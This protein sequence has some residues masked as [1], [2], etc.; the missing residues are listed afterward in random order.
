MSRRLLRFLYPLLI[1]VGLVVFASPAHAATGDC[2]KA[3]VAES[4]GSGLSGFFS[5]GAP[6]EIPQDPEGGAWENGAPIFHN[7]GTAG[8][9]FHTYDLGCVSGF[10]VDANMAKME[11]TV[12]NFGTIIPKTLTTMTA[13]LLGASYEP[14]YLAA[15]DPT[16][17]KGVDSLRDVVFEPWV[18]VSL[19]I[20][21]VG[22]LF[23]ARKAELAETVQHIGWGLLVLLVAAVLFQYPTAA[24]A[25]A[26]D[27]VP[28][29]HRARR[30]HRGC[31]CTSLA[32]V[33]GTVHA[34]R[35]RRLGSR[36]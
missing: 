20:I 10:D 24:G 33:V 7:Y 29:R 13:A 25:A 17:E 19:I 14:T 31:R 26:D 21:A 22:I 28:A 9:S 11:T 1:V 30:R 27:V 6:D 18:T 34:G 5:N 23:L 15:F 32:R 16:I 4:P 3:P 12:A 36:S 35:C 8:L 2:K